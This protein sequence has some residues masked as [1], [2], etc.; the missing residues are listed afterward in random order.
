MTVNF[1][2]VVKIMSIIF[3]VLGFSMIPALLVAI[4]YDETLC[5]SAFFST[6]FL[7]FGI[8]GIFYKMYQPQELKLKERDGFLIV[9]LCWLTASFVGAMPFV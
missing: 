8:G 5:N 2:N 7:C 1:N 3:F 4:I 6:I 9:A